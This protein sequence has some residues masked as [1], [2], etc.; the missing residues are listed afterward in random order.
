[1]SLASPDIFIVGAGPA[2]LAAGISASQAGFS[3]EIADC[4]APPI[5]KAC[6]E[7]LMPDSLA[8]LSELGVNLDAVETA[9]FAG[10]RFIGHGRVADSRFPT[11]T[12]LGVR[13]TVLHPLL[14]E[15]AESLGV[16]FRWKTVVRGMEDGSVKMDGGTVRP[17]WVVGAD[18][19]QSRVRHW[20]GLDRGKLSSKRVGL[21]QHFAITPWSEFVEIYWG[22]KGQAY[23][24]PVAKD[25]ICVAFMS[26]QKFASVGVA[27]EH[28]PELNERIGVA[29]RSDAPRGAV[30]LVKRLDRVSRGNVALIG[31]AS[32]SIDAITG[33]GMA[34]GFRQAVALT[35]AL[36]A[37]D[38]NQY[39][40]AH[41]VIGRVP[42]FMSEGMLMMDRMG[43]VQRHVLKALAHKPELFARMLKIHVG[44][45]ELKVL[46]REG[47]LNLG[48]GLLI[49]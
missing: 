25:E 21:R 13:R 28:F 26:R 16:R 5:D 18:G 12:G 47:L 36:K 6:G 10:V 32:G 49:A 17:R 41:Q 2:G 46:G 24:T 11:G 33:E 9:P 42:H 45:T 31:D 39:E 4:S 22:E 30:S 3:V 1:L 40:V 34:V 35:A 20:A 19:H 8:A 7:G 23:V 27:L 43:V 48:L 15:R 37:G 38:L 29:V 44:H 14:M